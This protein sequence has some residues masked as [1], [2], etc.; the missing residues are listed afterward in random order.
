MCIGA[1]EHAGFPFLA[2]FCAAK[3]KSPSRRHHFPFKNQSLTLFEFMK[4]PVV[5]RPSQGSFPKPLLVPDHAIDNLLPTF[6]ECFSFFDRPMIGSQCRGHGSCCWL[7][8]FKYLPSIM[9]IFSRPF[10]R[11]NPRVRRCFLNGCIWAA[12]TI[13]CVYQCRTPQQVVFA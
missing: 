3:P 2:K 7:A 6:K 11:K 12:N 1:V 5:K 4:F 9:L 13:C 8:H 10:R